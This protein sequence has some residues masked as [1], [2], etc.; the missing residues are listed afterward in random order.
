MIDPLRAEFGDVIGW[1]RGLPRPRVPAARWWVAT[2]YGMGAQWLALTLLSG[3]IAILFLFVEPPQIVVDDV[4]RTDLPIRPAATAI[5]AATAAAVARRAGGWWAVAGLAGLFGL[6]ALLAFATRVV[7]CARFAEMGVGLSMCP[8]TLAHSVPEL[9]PALVGGGFGVALTAALR[10]SGSAPSALLLAAAFVVLCGAVVG[11][12]TVP[13]RPIG[14]DAYPWAVATTAAYA[15]IWLACG[16]LARMLGG[17]RWTI[18]AL[19][20]AALLPGVF[21]VYQWVTLRPSD[22][23]AL[24]WLTLAPLAFAG[25]ALL[26]WLVAADAPP[27]RV[28]PRARRDSAT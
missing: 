4:V 2:L 11:V 16:A 25:L 27:G 13:F 21:P 26:G 7:D 6:G 3:A 28:K 5:A 15:V 22:G 24:Q 19:A 9:I 23:D 1:A 12:V 17:G 10:A 8:P 20:V 18:A 14:P